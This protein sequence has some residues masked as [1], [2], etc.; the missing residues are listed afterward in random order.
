ML[1][2]SEPG[3]ETRKEGQAAFSSQLGEITEPCSFL[4]FGDHRVSMR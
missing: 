1:T 3:V 4:F 2:P